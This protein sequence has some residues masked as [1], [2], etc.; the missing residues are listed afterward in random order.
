MEFRASPGCAE[1]LPVEWF[2]GDVSYV[3]QALPA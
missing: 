2:R 1:Q 3:E